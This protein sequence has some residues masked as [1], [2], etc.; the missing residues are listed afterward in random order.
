MIRRFQRL[1]GLRGDIRG[2]TALD[3]PSS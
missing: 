2:V 3:G 1:F